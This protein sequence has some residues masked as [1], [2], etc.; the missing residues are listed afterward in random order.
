MTPRKKEPQTL[1]AKFGFSDPDLKTPK[2]DEIM[3]WLDE[4]MR[5]VV[6][7]LMGYPPEREWK[8]AYLAETAAKDIPRFE[9]RRTEIAKA[10]EDPHCVFREA[11]IAELALIPNDLASMPVPEC[12]AWRIARKVWEQPIVSGTKYTVGFVDMLVTLDSNPHL[13]LDGLVRTQYE[14]DRITRP[15][16][17]KVGYRN[18]EALAFEVKPTIPSL[19]E[20]I[21]Q[22]RFYETYEKWRYVVVSPDTRW[23][24][25]LADQNIGFVEVPA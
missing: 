2:H 1:Q 11:K 5:Q 14:G 6:T 17:W 23:V 22:I 19:G 15:P 4:S 16:R 10:I 24:K 21:R 9:Q 18:L 3:V 25:Q 12:V 20:L 8:P 13:Y 7:G